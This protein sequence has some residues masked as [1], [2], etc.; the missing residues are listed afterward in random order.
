MNTQYS[1]PNNFHSKEFIISLILFYFQSANSTISY[2]NKDTS[3]TFWL[4]AQYIMSSLF[5]EGDCGHCKI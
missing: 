4:L 3:G 1:I 2:I 5:F